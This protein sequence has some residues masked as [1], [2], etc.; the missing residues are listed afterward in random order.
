MSLTVLGHLLVTERYRQRSAKGA[1]LS[2]PY[3]LERQVEPSQNPLLVTNSRGGFTLTHRNQEGLGRYGIAPCKLDDEPKAIR[4]LFESISRI[5]RSSGWSNRFAGVPEALAS[6]RASSF[7][8]HAIVLPQALV[9][10]LTNEPR[11]P[12]H[13]GDLEGL[14]VFSSDLPPG[15]ALLVT[16]PP[17]LGVYTRIGDYLGLQL[18]N[19]RQT[20]AVVWSDGVVG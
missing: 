18:F 7:S 8:P 5:S 15:A 11:L 3:L 13:L 2:I 6:M 19:V 9:T 20:V 14:K 10:S 17:A 4:A 1:G 16:A 12:P